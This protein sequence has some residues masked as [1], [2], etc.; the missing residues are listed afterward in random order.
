[1][2]DRTVVFN[3]EIA[4]IYDNWL[5]TPAGRYIDGREKSLI[6]DLIAP[7]GGERVLDVGCGTGDH[8][9]LFR[10]KG[11]DVT[12]IDPSPAM[13]KLAGK[14]LGNRADFHLGYAEDLPFSDNEFDIVT[15]VTSLE[16]A[17]D[18]DTAIAEAIR[19]CRGRVFLGVLNKYSCLGL[20]RRI[21][22]ARRPSIYNHARFFHIGELNAMIRNNLQGIRIRWGSVIF[23]PEGWYGF[24]R[25]LEEAIP[26]M[27]NPFGAFFGLSFP[28]TFTYATIQEPILE[29]VNIAAQTRQPAP[30]AVRGMK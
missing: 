18:P 3:E 23:L 22:G 28:V 1:M 21:R 19:V 4:S 8:L 26:V 30:G 14:K 7:R 27:K 5:Q 24:A 12:G 16:F 6:L 15:L 10:R 17:D 20:S 9:L 11:C 13:L 2:K 25:K 29:T